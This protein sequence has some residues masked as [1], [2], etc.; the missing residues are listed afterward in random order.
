MPNISKMHVTSAIVHNKINL[1]KR[2]I[3]LYILLSYVKYYSSR[4]LPIHCT[5][6]WKLGKQYKMVT[7]LL[8]NIKQTLKFPFKDTAYRS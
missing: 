7:Q 1:L 8:Q 5:K 2:D 4:L 6:K 3:L